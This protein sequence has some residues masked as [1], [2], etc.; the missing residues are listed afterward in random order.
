MNNSVGDFDGTTSVAFICLDSVNLSN[1]QHICCCRIY[2]RA[3]D[4]HLKNPA[5]QRLMCSVYCEYYLLYYQQS[6]KHR[7]FFTHSI[8][9]GHEKENG[10]Y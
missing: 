10:G 1:L 2:E 5:S 9:K 8:K 3:I 7:S 6:V 4:V